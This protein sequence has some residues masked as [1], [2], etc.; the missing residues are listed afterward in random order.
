MT[1]T[2]DSSNNNYSSPSSSHTDHPPPPPTPMLNHI[3]LVIPNITI[4]TKITLR[5][6]KGMYNT[7]SELFKIH[8]QV[9]QVIN[10]IIPSKSA[11]NPSLKTID[12]Q[13]WLSLDTF[14]LHLI[15]GTISD[16]LLNTITERNSTTEIPWNLLF[17]IF[18]DNKN[19][20]ALY[21]E[22]EFLRTHTE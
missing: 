7:W 13:L 9:F 22:Q 21:L 5:I 4:F 19:S 8:A 12:P 11:A 14:L 3:A 16:D 6:E 15:Y 2:T 20:R 17:D 18:Y 10:H 1:T